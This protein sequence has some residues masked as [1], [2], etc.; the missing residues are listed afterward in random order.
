MGVTPIRAN[1][2]AGTCEKDSTKRGTLEKVSVANGQRMTNSA[3]LQEKLCLRI[4]DTRGMMR[5]WFG[6]VWE[7][8]EARN[9][10]TELI[11]IKGNFALREC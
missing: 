1:F 2:R 8:V 3:L 10:E 11:L 6:C 7:T 5:D 4:C 9:I